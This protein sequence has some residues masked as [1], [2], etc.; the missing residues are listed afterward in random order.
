[1]AYR[2][3]NAAA[4]ASLTA[5]R[6]T[7]FTGRKWVRWTQRM[8]AEFLD[9]LAATCNVKASAE[10]IGV[11]V[12]SVYALRRRDAEFA[13]EWQIALESGYQLLETLVLGH[14]LSGAAREDG[15]ATPHDSARLD[16]DTALRLLT[17]HRNASG[18]PSAEG[19]AP[20][21]RA[22]MADT[23]AA[24]LKKLKAIEKRRAT[25]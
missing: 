25:A 15:I 20:R 22:D 14:V 18:K 17:A 9:H 2:T 7:A 6:P 23:D 19:G 12:I 11:G 3:R 21:R 24:I 1:M 5:T 16:M 8:K 4:A 13:R 10:A